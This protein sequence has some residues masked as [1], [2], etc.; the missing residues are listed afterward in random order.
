M[1]KSIVN[2]KIIRGLFAKLTTPS[3]MGRVRGASAVLLLLLF[4]P[5]SISSYAQV[6]F[7]AR[8]DSMVLPIGEQCELTLDVTCDAS[9]KVKMPDFRPQ[10]PLHELVEIVD[11]LGT[12]TAFLNEGKRMQVQQRYTITAWDSALVLLPPFVVEVDGKR[13]ESKQLALKVLTMD[14]DT[15]HVDRFEPPKDIQNNPFFWDD[16]KPAIWLFVLNQCLLL[17]LL[18]L[19]TRWHEN[20]PLIKFIR[21]KRKLPAHQVAMNEI[22][23]IK[24]ERKWAEEDSKEYYTQLTDT[25]RNYI[26]ERY[27]FNAMEMTS[28]EII[29]RLLKE[30]DETALAELRQ[31]FQTADLVKFAKWTTMINENDANLV[32]AIDFINQTKIEVDPNA[33]TE[34]VIIPEETKQSQVRSFTLKVIMSVIGVI[35]LVLI[36]Y[37]LYIVIDLIR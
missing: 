34:E 8:I 11:Y 9:Q 33:P 18:W 5:L 1:M 13:Y 20:K 17:I 28:A 37:V 7:E 15:V 22:E 27:G 36:G 19:Y 23:R 4:L 14:V 32:S 2:N 25:L 35:A 30:Q 26:H 21:R 16:W 6:I 12:D 10:Q 29:E 24:G 31:L 3:L